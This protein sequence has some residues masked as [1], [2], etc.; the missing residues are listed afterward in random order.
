[1]HTTTCMM[2]MM[3]DFEIIGCAFIY[4]LTERR[5]AISFHKFVKE[6]FI[7][8]SMHTLINWKTFNHS[9]IK[10]ACLHLKKKDEFYLF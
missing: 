8:K 7:L 10:S 3:T 5:S 9:T 6:L 1:M 4:F 2:K